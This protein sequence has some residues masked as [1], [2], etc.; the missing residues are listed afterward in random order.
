MNEKEIK[1]LKPIDFDEMWSKWIAEVK[2]IP[3]KVYMNQIEK[4]DFGS[5]KTFF[6]D[7]VNNTKVFARLYYNETSVNLK[8]PLIVFYHGFGGSSADEYYVK[9][10]MYWVRKGF[11]VLMMDCRN[12]GGQTFDTNNY[13]FMDKNYYCRGLLDKDKVYDKLLYQDALKL[14]E[15]S[16]DKSLE[17]FEDLY[18]KEIIVVGPSQGGQISLAV[19]ALSDIP[20]LCIP[21]IPSGCA[22]IS[23]IEGRYGKYTPYDDIIKENPQYKDLIYNNI[24][25]TDIIN[26]ASKITCPVFSS[27]G[28]VDNICPMEYYLFAYDMIKTQKEV[29]FYEGYGHGGFDKYHFPKKLEFVFKN[30]DK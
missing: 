4:K 13:C 15:I 16:R 17:P 27:V 9:K 5:I 1:H 22:I 7:S 11:S 18:D 20:E 14:L 8:R 25:Y 30:I 2:N 26:M 19:A 3:N 21:D 6:F 12:Q 29:L 24:S 23:R 28:T 10:T